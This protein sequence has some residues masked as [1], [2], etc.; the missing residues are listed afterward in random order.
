MASPARSS[1]SY[2]YPR[3]DNDMSVFH[4]FSVRLWDPL[5][6]AAS[7]FFFFRRNLRIKPRETLKMRWLVLIVL[8]SLPSLASSLVLKT[9]IEINGVVVFRLRTRRP[10]GG[11]WRYSE[12]SLAQN[13]PSLNKNNDYLK[14]V[15]LAKLKVYHASFEMKVAYCYNYEIVVGFLS[16]IRLQNNTLFEKIS[17]AKQGQYSFMS[18]VTACNGSVMDV[19]R[20]LRCGLAESLPGYGSGRNNIQYFLRQQLFPTGIPL[21]FRL[22]IR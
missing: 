16:S 15:L 1:S 21:D 22:V 8:G 3:N 7:A 2:L 19:P 12:G 9:G 6:L 17:V 5:L 18:S 13:R 4:P 10:L 14:S 20:L 11:W